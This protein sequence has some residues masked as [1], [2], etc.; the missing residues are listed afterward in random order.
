ME[1]LLP[2]PKTWIE[3]IVSHRNN[4]THQSIAE[5]RVERD[6]VDLLRCNHVLAA[7]LEL[8]F[9]KTMGLDAEQRKALLHRSHRHKQLRRRFFE[10]G[11]V[12][13]RQD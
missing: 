9:L 8:C 10:N 2:A 1:A 4:F 6:K 7:L 3:P 11:A 5:T 13:C 12:S